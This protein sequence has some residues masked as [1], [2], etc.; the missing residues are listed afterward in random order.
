MLE[1]FTNCKAEMKVNGTSAELTLKLAN[2]EELNYKNIDLGNDLIIGDFWYGFNYKAAE[3][4]LNIWL[5]EELKT[6]FATIY[7][8]KDGEIDVFISKRIS[9]DVIGTVKEK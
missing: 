7:V 6:Y 4:D 9:I 1:D 3:Y 2:G 8:V 5:N